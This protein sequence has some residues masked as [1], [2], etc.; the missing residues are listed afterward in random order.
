MERKKAVACTDEDLLAF[1]FILNNK[2]EVGYSSS[3]LM[4]RQEIQKFFLEVK[5]NM[6]VKKRYAKVLLQIL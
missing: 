4:F 1:K 3:N 5:L 2:E 6:T